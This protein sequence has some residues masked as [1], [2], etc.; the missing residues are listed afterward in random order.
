MLLNFFRGR[1]LVMVRMPV[2]FVSDFMSYIRP[3]KDKVDVSEYL[4]RRIK[5]NRK[6]LTSS[7]NKLFLIMIHYI[8]II[9]LENSI[10]FL[11]KK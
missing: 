1:Y 3:S 6:I 11:F 7:Y 10:D 5:R 4:T 9:S 8:K 2:H